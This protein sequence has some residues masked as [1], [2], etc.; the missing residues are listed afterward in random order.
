MG[1][2]FTCLTTRAVHLEIANTL[3]ADSAIMALRRLAARRGSPLVMYSDNGTNFKGACTELKD[4]IAK[5]DESKQHEYALQNG[6]KWLFNPPDAPHMGGSWERLIR[7]IKIA[8]SATLK[9]EVQCDEV[10]YTVITEIEHSINSRPLTHV[11][12]D[13]R[14]RESL[15]PNHF[16]IGCSSGNLKLGSYDNANACT[17]KQWRIAQMLADTFWRRWLREYVP[18]LLTRKKW[19][20]NVEDT[21][22]NDVVMIVDLQAPRNS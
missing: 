22:V 13:P 8:L 2:I 19:T 4:E 18:T 6:M 10:L 15:T 9:N 14:D 11:S 12:T 5:I 21:Q 1:V 20:E 7:S 16:L 17:K 3:S